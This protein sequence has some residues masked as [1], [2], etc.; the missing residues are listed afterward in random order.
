ME[1]INDPI[2]VHIMLNMI[3]NIT[4]FKVGKV[5]PDK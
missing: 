2:V 4:G 1:K 5:N 3:K